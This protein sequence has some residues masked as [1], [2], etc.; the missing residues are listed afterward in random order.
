MR[1]PVLFL[2]IAPALTAQINV[3]DPEYV[4]PKE[5]PFTSAADLQTGQKLFDGQCAGCHGPNGEG[6]RGAILAQPRLRRAADDESIFRV[7]RFGIRGTEMPG[8]HAL[9]TR[10]TW[11][12]AA[13]VRSL[14]RI[15]PEAVPG[16][17]RQGEQIYRAKG[18]CASCH[19]IAGTGGN[20]GPELTGI[21]DSRSAA[22]LRKTLL[23]PASTLPENFLQVRLI[24]RDGRRITGIRINEDTF[25][26]QVR[27]F[28]G[29]IYSFMK[30]D[31]RD[32]QKD[33]SK[34]PMPAYGNILSPAETDDLIAYLTS[35]RGKE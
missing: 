16:N 21:G 4:I 26:I 30:Q 33:K 13:W 6:G 17:A 9:T 5:N 15:A 7:I 11:Q 20:L 14:G 34:T 8:G 35:L 2:A 1:L 10:E 32:L 18:N 31:L 19:T 3:V 27:D 25:T 12:V 23:D 28:S 29:N 24:S 22:H